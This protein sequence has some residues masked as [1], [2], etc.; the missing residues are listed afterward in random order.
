M[1]ERTRTLFVHVAPV[2]FGT[3]V[4]VYPIRLLGSTH[5]MVDTI[6][7]RQ[8]LLGKMSIGGTGRWLSLGP[9]FSVWIKEEET[10]ELLV[11]ESNCW[12]TI[13]DG[14]KLVKRSF[15][16]SLCATTLDAVTR[17]ASQSRRWRGK[18]S[19]QVHGDGR[20]SR[21]R[22]WNAGDESDDVAGPT[23][24]NLRQILPELITKFF[25]VFWWRK[26]LE[27]AMSADRT[28][29][30][31]DENRPTGEHIALRLLQLSAGAFQSENA[32]GWLSR[33][34]LS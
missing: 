32:I 3:V 23:R 24:T 16:A 15:V 7:H 12:H 2:E 5:R 20:G 28:V 19:F 33:L 18:P 9:L 1:E 26:I 4:R 25:V 10:Q 27:S 21:A 22:M 11:V 29:W 17:R 14:L 13:L 8:D 6:Q 30:S 31:I 34:A